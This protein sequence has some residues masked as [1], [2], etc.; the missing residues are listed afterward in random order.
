MAGDGSDF[1]WLVSSDICAFPKPS[2]EFPVFNGLK[3]NAGCPPVIFNILYVGVLLPGGSR[4]C[5]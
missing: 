3:A 1:A 2:A 5:G 4:K